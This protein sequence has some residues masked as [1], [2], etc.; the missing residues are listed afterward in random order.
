[1]FDV[2]KAIQAFQAYQA[3]TWVKGKEGKERE[4]NNLPMNDIMD[5]VEYAITRHMNALLAAVKR[6]VA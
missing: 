5:A 1:L 4:D 2:Q 6:M 3:S